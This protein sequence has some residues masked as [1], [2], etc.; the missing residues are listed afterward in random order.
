VVT[1]IQLPVDAVQLGKDAVHL[2]GEDGGGRRIDGAGHGGDAPG[3]ETDTKL[4]CLGST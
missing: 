1:H 3:L 2:H 4:L